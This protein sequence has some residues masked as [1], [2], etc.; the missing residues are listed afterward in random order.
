M[1][2]F[3]K[4]ADQLVEEPYKADK[5]RKKRAEY[6]EE[7]RKVIEKIRATKCFGCER[8]SYHLT[9]F[10]QM[11]TYKTQLDDIHKILSGGLDAKEQEFN[12]RTAVLTNYKIVDNDLNML[13]KGKV[14]V[15]VSSADNILLTEF[16]FSGLLSELTDQEILAIVS[17]LNNQQKAPGNQPECIKMYS[18]SYKK[19][20]AFI[21]SETE[22]LIALEE[23]FGINEEKNFSKRLNFKFYEAV[24]DW[25]DGCDFI[26]IINDC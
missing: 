13:F 12:S 5:K 11:K 4:I 17:L 18:E 2:Q 7:Q 20:Y 23:A 26:D 16:F 9:Q 19:A 24:Y 14:A 6:V 15:K 10:D 25:A 3:V 21:I 22:K 8:I 1:Q